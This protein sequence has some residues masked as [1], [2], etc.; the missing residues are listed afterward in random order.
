MNEQDFW[1][2]YQEEIG[3]GDEFLNYIFEQVNEI[4]A[5]YKGEPICAATEYSLTQI[6]EVFIQLM[7][8]ELIT[9]RHIAPSVF[10]R[11]CY[12]KYSNLGDGV[13]FISDEYFNVITLNVDVILY[14]IIQVNPTF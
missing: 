2:K 4:I 13:L 3:K 10:K 12:D 5:P 1:K 11:H 7:G 9:L 6:L 14:K 8:N